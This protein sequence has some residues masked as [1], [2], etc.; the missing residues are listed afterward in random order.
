MVVYP[1]CDVRDALKVQ[2]PAGWDAELAKVKATGYKEIKGNYG[3]VPADTVEQVCQQHRISPQT[4]K[5]SVD[6]LAAEHGDNGVKILN[7]NQDYTAELKIMAMGDDR[8]FSTT[9]ERPYIF[10]TIAPG[11]H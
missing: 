10:D 6:K 4:I 9:A 1:S 2:K 8:I 11:L 7:E 3:V 5:T